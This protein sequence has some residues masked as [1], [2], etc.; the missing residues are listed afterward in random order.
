MYCIQLIWDAFIVSIR[1]VAC[2]M[3]KCT[4]TYIHYTLLVET[5]EKHQTRMFIC[6]TNFFFSS[7]S[8]MFFY[9]SFSCL[10]LFI[11]QPFFR[12]F[13]F[14]YTSV[15]YRVIRQ[16]K[17]FFLSFFHTYTPAR[18]KYANCTHSIKHTNVLKKLY[19]R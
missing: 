4:S 19:W 16:M 13:D 2:S 17:E 7:T 10:Y 8:T 15:V 11:L 5:H 6:E 14:S 12:F 9:S 18:C 1:P 3:C